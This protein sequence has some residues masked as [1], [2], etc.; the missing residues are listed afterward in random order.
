MKNWNWAVLW[1]NTV[2]FY[3][4]ASWGLSKYIENKLQTT[5]FHLI[6]S[7][8]KKRKRF[9]TSLFASFSAYFLKK[10]LL[11]LYYINWPN[12]IVW[13][14]LLCEI[15]SN[16]CITIVCKP[17]CDAMNFEVNLILLIKPFS[18]HDQKV[19]TKTEISTEWKELLR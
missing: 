14:P 1:I 6:L 9:G 3:C 5:F 11:L 10:I 18:L 16:M 17:G 19:V 15:L 7:F 2:C 4:M 12:F 8:Y 13:L